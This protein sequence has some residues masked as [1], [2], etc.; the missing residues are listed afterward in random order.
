MAPAPAHEPARP[1]ARPR[2]GGLTLMASASTPASRV[3]YFGRTGRLIITPVFADRG[4]T[5][6]RVLGFLF[7]LLAGL[8]AGVGSAAADWQLNRYSDLRFAIEFP[9]TPSAS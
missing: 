1:R 7:L 8:A 4:A 9:G 5:I 6:M 2:S 3:P